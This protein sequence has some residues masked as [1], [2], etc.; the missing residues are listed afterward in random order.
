MKMTKMNFMHMFFIMLCVCFFSCGKAKEKPVTVILN[1]ELVTVT[2]SSIILTWTTDEPGNSVVLIGTTP[3]EL[4]EFHCNEPKTKWH[5]CEVTGLEPETT[6]YYRT[7]SGGV[8]GTPDEYSPGYVTTLRPPHGEFLFQF[9][10]MNDVHV[11]EEVAGLIIIGD[12][13]LNEGFTWQDENNPYWL[14]MNNAAVKEINERGADFVIIKGD[15]TSEHRKEEFE[16][17]KEIFSLLTMPYFVLR[18][19]HD[20]IDDDPENYYVNVFDLENYAPLGNHYTIDSHGHF[21]ISFDYKGIH[22]VGLDSADIDG[23]GKICD[24]ELAWLQADLTMNQD[25]IALIFL[26]H[27]V[28]AQS[29]DVAGVAG[30][31]NDSASREQFLRIISDN[32]QVKAVFSGHTHRNKVN[33][34]DSAPGVVFAETGSTKE[35]PG[36]YT[37]YRVYSGGFMSNFYKSSCPECREWSDITRG[38]YDF[39]GG[40]Q[41]VLFGE[42]EDRNYVKEW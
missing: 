41:V 32:P 28:V 10:T 21:Y 18:G 19:N 36:G 5:Y 29:G 17:A 7:K 26:H 37:I 40:G 8:V 14:F 38:E 13:V 4:N 16:K 33:Y 23:G 12:Q 31:L 3:E 34:S 1:E 35:Y 27:P 2:D 20:R 11:G 9:A 22:F 30:I 24:E 39:L 15:I 25:K 42:L 6:Y